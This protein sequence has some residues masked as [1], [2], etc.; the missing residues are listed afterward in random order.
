MYVSGCITCYRKEIAEGG[1]ILKEK[2]LKYLPK[3]ALFN[4]KG[5]YEVFCGHKNFNFGLQPDPFPGCP[6]TVSLQL[7][8]EVYLHVLP[9]TTVHGRINSSSVLSKNECETP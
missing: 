5:I 9:V 3:I 1:E 7:I 6:N 4:G 8:F 2:M